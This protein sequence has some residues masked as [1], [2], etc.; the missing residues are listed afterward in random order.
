MPFTPFHLGPALLV[1]VLLYRWLDPVPLLLA[2]IAVD[3]R[4]ILVFFGVLGGPLHGLLHTLPG[5]VAVGLVVAA[6]LSLVADRYAAW[7]EAAGV[8]VPVSLDRLAVSG[9][10][11]AVLLHLLPD[12]LMYGDVGLLQPFHPFLQQSVL[13]LG[14][15]YVAAVVMGVAGLGLAAVVL[16]RENVS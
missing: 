13:G 16:Y 15:V 3:A 1:A 5:A 14:R 10:V 4:A 8:E 9:L 11:G 7:F 6:G 2:S 12:A